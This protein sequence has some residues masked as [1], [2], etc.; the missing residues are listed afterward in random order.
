MTQLQQLSAHAGYRD[1]S[2]CVLKSK[3]DIWDQ[4]DKA[5]YIINGYVYSTYH[6]QGLETSSVLE[7]SQAKLSN[8]DGI[9]IINDPKHVIDFDGAE[10]AHQTVNMS[11]PAFHT[12]RSDEFVAWLWKNVNEKF[13]RVRDGSVKEYLGKKKDV[14]TEVTDEV[15]I[16]MIKAIHELAEKSKKELE[17]IG[18][19]FI[20]V[21]KKI[22]DEYPE[23]EKNKPVFEE[24]KTVVQK[25][26]TS[27]NHVMKEWTFQK[28]KKDLE[29][30]RLADQGVEDQ[31]NLWFYDQDRHFWSELSKPRIQKTSQEIVRKYNLPPALIIE[32][33]QA[34]AVCDRLGVDVARDVVLDAEW[35]KFRMDRIFDNSGKFWDMEKGCIRD[36]DPSQHYF[37]TPDVKL[38]LQDGL[39]KPAKVFDYLKARY[40]KYW[41]IV[42]DHIA[43]A[44]LHPKSLGSKP[45]ILFIVGD[46]DTWKSVIVEMLR[47]MFDNRMQTAISLEKM[48]RDDQFVEGR[49]A[50][51]RINLT[52][53]ESANRLHNEAALKNIVTTH[54]DFVRKMRSQKDIWVWMYPRWIVCTN[55][56]PLLP[57]NAHT[58]SILNRLLYVETNKFDEKEPDWRKEIDRDEIQRYMMHILKRAHE[59]HKNPKSIHVQTEN[60][61]RSMYEKLG[62]DQFETHINQWYIK[63][64]EYCVLQANFRKWYYEVEKETVSPRL[65]PDKCKEQ[66]LTLISAQNQFHVMYDS[67]KRAWRSC[68]WDASGAKRKSVILG[69][70]PKKTVKEYTK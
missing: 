57:D 49:M 42:D 69:I 12:M 50:N 54:Q 2:V 9:E 10:P 44:V 59:I 6:L 36:T 32:E 45:H 26:L 38:P 20:Y 5:Q 15:Y 48:S 60:E 7:M 41:K 37:Q 52:E 11:R 65:L 51:K 64:D 1:E 40:G 68:D 17:E 27:P 63:D 25:A 62:R 30:V 21:L 66:D 31:W 13:K 24:C 18:S 58:K 67:E 43:S 22:N 28:A 56:V 4:G 23:L 70:R 8:Y 3:Q 53:E 39:G 61:S 19:K 46:T 14:P 47:D 33:R 34:K 35:A 55:K 16:V 29:F